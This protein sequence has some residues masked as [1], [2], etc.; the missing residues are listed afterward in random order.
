MIALNKFLIRLKV[1][2][3]ILTKKH[4]HW[5]IVDIDKENLVKLIKEEDYEIKEIYYHGIRPY[6]MW[7]IIHKIAETKDFADMVIEKA[8]F[9][10]EAENYKRKKK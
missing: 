10:L 9:E 2:Y 5:F 8:N 1:C 3:Y 6:L 7:K 4:K